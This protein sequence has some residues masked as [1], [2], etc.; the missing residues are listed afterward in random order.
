MSISVRACFALCFA[1]SA[2]ERGFESVATEAADAEVGSAPAELRG[3]IEY[4]SGTGC[5]DPMRF[6]VEESVF[7]GRVAASSTAVRECL[8]DAIVGSGADY[9]DHDLTTRTTTQAAIGPY[10]ACDGE[11]F[12][13]DTAAI[14]LARVIE[15]M[16]SAN[17]LRIRCSGG[18]GNASVDSGDM[19]PWGHLGLERMRLGVWFSNQ[20][21]QIENDDVCSL[22]DRGVRPGCRWA[23][24]PWPFSQAAGTI[25]HEAAHTHSYSHGGND[26]AS[27][28]AACDQTSNPSWNY[29]VNTMPYILGN[30]IDSVLY[31]SG[32][33]CGDINSCPNGQLRLTSTYGGTSCEC[34]SATSGTAKYPV[35]VEVR[36]WGPMA[37]SPNVEVDVGG[38]CLGCIVHYDG[39]DSRVHVTMSEPV[40]GTPLS[41]T[42]RSGSL[43]C[44]TSSPTTMPAGGFR[45]PLRASCYD[46][47]QIITVL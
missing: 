32:F 14:Q 46:T 28:I 17:D 47:A 39:P 7:M 12:A 3:D 40:E 36:G 44:A 34:V 11:P 6:Y 24:Y 2:C 33:Q 10:G 37:T 4:A 45:R 19:E 13:D 30:C 18:S 27:A 5:S 21:S 1:I 22:A 41:L 9:Y 42:A 35:R 8:E 26:Q 29:Q 23:P 38:A 25:W 43:D 31:D 20:L 15:M 16:E